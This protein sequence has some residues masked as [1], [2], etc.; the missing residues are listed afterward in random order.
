METAG[1]IKRI[2]QDLKIPFVFKSSY[3][4]ANRSRL[5]SFTGIGE[6]EGLEILR[7]V[8]KHYKFV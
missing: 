8:K 3:K 7:D 6:K 4:K 5:D 1:Q 2:T